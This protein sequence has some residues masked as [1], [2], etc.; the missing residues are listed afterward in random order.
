MEIK[1]DKIIV[2]CECG[3]HL[4]MVESF[5]ESYGKVSS[6]SIYLAMFKYGYYKPKFWRRIALAWDYLISGGEMYSDQIILTPQEAKKLV[7]FINDNLIE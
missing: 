4:L 3:G 2:E 5:V 6:H 7:K 1:Q